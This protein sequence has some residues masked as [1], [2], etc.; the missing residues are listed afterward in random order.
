MN[1]IIFLV[2]RLTHAHGGGYS[3]MAP[4]SSAL[5][6]IDGD[7]PGFFP[8]EIPCI[9]CKHDD[10]KQSPLHTYYPAFSNICSNNQLCYGVMQ[11]H[12]GDLN[13]R[14]NYIL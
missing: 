12:P 5:L 10:H 6:L 11:Y 4:S 1:L 13:H 7:C 14:M 2:F 8:G 9:R 3:Q